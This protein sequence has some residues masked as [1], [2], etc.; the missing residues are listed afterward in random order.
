MTTTAEVAQKLVELCRQGKFNEVQE[1][2]FAD[3]A[4][5]CR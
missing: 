3:N 5:L 1:T 2:L 4:Q